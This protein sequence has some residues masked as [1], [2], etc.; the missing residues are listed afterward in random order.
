MPQLTFLGTGTSNGIPVIGCDCAV[1][2]SS[3]PR[4]RRSRS[5]AVVHVGERAFLIDTAT[6]LRLQALAVGLRRV[7][8]V[9]MTHPHADHTGGF[10]DLRRFNELQGRHLPVFADPGTAAVLADRFAYTFADQYAFYGGKPDLTLHPVDGPFD[11]D[12]CKVVPIPVFHGRLPILGYRFGD[13]AYVTDA[14]TILDSSLALL[15]GLDV[16]V[17]NALRERPHPT[18]LSLPEAVAIVRKL[19]PRAA[20]LTHLSHELG[21]AAAT[22]LL[23]AGIEVAFDGLTVASAGTRMPPP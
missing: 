7:D 2:R 13:L 12:G 1:C 11:L 8:A 19:R 15:E 9:L 16:L 18:H 22:A 4:D 10:D 5:S 21:H 3:D 20:Y 14:K 17:L 6:E 23:P